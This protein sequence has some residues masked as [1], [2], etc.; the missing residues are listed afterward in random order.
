MLTILNWL[1]TVNILA[2]LVFLDFESLEPVVVRLK[3]L[4]K[5][6][7][8]VFHQGQAHTRPSNNEFFLVENGDFGNNKITF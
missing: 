2:S 6:L 7:M 4:Q 1:L 3:L 5:H 8:L